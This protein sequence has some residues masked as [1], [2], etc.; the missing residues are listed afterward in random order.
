MASK[1]KRT[2]SRIITLFEWSTK[3]ILD[4]FPQK[5]VISEEHTQESPSVQ[6]NI[7]SVPNRQYVFNILKIEKT[8]IKEILVNLAEVVYV[9]DHQAQEQIENTII[10]SA[11]Y[12][13]ACS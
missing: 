2:Y 6:L 4:S 1:D 11:P 13:I 9:E 5:H 12:S 3:K 10:S 7:L 8:S